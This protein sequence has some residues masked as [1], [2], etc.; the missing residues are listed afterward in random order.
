[1]KRAY[2]LLADGFEVIEALA[3]VDV[4]KRGGVEV[5]TL[6]IGD[7]LDVASSQQ[8][9]VQ[10]DA[11]L[12]AADLSDGDALVLP[13]GYPGYE[14]LAAEGAVLKVVV[15]YCNSGRFVAAICGAPT[16]LVAAGVAGGRLM[17]CHSGV[18]EAMWGCQLSDKSVEQDA[19]IITG[20]GA[21]HSIEFA[22]CLLEALTDVGTV[23][24]VRRAMELD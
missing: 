21:G 10:A 19:N 23:D 8:I 2:V 24:G 13:G 12:S 1:M 22:L 15:D 17:T 16:V 6:S 20:I 7:S 18:R 3:T 9:V 5:V 14:N 11:L 4:L